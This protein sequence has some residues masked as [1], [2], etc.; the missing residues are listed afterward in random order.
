VK[1]VSC[2]NEADVIGADYVCGI[3]GAIGSYVNTE[4]TVWGL[5]TVTGSITATGTN[6]SEKYITA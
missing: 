5:N 1:I 2:K 4:E 3:A 6:T